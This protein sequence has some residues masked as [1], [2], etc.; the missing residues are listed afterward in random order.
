MTREEMFNV[1]IHYGDWD[2]LLT[3]TDEEMSRLY[4]SFFEEEE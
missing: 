4:K 1:L 3:L 2:Y